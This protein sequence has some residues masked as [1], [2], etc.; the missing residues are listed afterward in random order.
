MKMQAIV[1]L[2]LLGLTMASARPQKDDNEMPM[3]VRLLI[4]IA[5]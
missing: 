5:G 2:C 4:D 1:M 3:P